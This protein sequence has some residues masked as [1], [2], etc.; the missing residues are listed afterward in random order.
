MFYLAVAIRTLVILGLIAVAV[1]KAW[2]GELLDVPLAQLTLGGIILGLV[3]IAVG[4]SV[5]MFLLG[6][7]IVLPQK[8]NRFG[9]SGNW[10]FFT[11]F[12]GL[13]L[14]LPFWATTSGKNGAIVNFISGIVLSGLGWLTS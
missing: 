8:E 14:S 4:L 5:S 9:W 11:L 3:K 2:P 7:I 1:H 12:A 6:R 10:V 13:V